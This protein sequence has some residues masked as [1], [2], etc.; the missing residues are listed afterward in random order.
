MPVNEAEEDDPRT[1]RRGI[2]GR[3]ARRQGTHGSGWGTGGS[4]GLQIQWQVVILPAVGSIPTRSRQP[5]SWAE[6]TG[7]GRRRVPGAVRSLHPEERVRLRPRTRKPPP[8]EGGTDLLPAFLAL[9][10]PRR[11]AR[12]SPR[13]VLPPMPLNIRAAVG[14]GEGEQ[15]EPG[16]PWPGSS[17]RKE[18][19]DPTWP[20]AWPGSRPGSGWLRW[21][22]PPVG[23]RR[24]PASPPA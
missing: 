13:P 2:P 11:G 7:R 19:T 6:D 24:G 8:R 4:P 10:C 5:I 9:G 16:V 20:G 23:R 15:G 3:E 18:G 22:R 1:A 21:R 12:R 14:L 17:G